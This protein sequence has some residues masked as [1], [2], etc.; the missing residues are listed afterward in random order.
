M[1]VLWGAAGAV[2]LGLGAIGIVLPLVPTVPFVLLAAFCFSR[3]SDR[4]HDWLV[5]HKV[6]GPPIRDWRESGAISR[7]GKRYA[8][9]SIGA[10]F[11]VSLVIGLRPALLAIQATVL[12]AVLLFIWTR[13]TGSR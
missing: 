13:P 12:S 7:R 6:F 10:V 11:A 1:R 9:V 4:M 2:A 3:S 8:S 5:E